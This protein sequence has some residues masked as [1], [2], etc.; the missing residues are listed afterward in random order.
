MDDQIDLDKFAE[1]STGGKRYILISLDIRT[2]DN[3]NCSAYDFTIRQSSIRITVVKAD[4]GKRYCK[5]EQL[6]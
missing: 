2:V 1:F 6:Y 4:A 3:D 5:V